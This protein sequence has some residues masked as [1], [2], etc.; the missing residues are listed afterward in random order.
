MTGR[1]LAA[2]DDT[3]AAT[4]VLAVAPALAEL[5][6]ARVD[7]VHVAE[8]GGATVRAIADRA[9]YELRVLHGPVVDSLRTAGEEPDVVAVAVGVRRHGAV[10]RPAGH[11]VV[12]LATQ[13][14]K[15]VAVVPPAVV[16]PV[17]I[18]RV[19]VPMDRSHATAATLGDAIETV[20]KQGLEVTLLH[21]HEEGSAIPAF[22]DQPQH[23]IP[24]WVEEFVARFAPTADHEA[25]VELRVGSAP[26]HVLGVAGDLG[27]D[28]ILLGW[29]QDL[30]PGH[31]AVVR[32]VLES[33]EVPVVLVPVL[34]AGGA[35]G[36]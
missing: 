32:R 15:P 5:L 22:V 11:V 18:R 1:L 3:P 35:K 12:G 19:L 25:C 16:A 21:V 10:S 24:A 4:A 8:D 7:A 31:A 17:T 26:D 2:L 6:G 34:A 20:C 30:T 9:G 29:S 23:E 27:A 13:L 33:S 28:L 14:R 36:G